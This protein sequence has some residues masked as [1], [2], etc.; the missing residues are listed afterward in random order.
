[1]AE[2]SSREIVAERRRDQGRRRE[3]SEELGS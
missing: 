1:M 3:V 2:E